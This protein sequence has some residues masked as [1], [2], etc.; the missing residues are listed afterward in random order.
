M[1]KYYLIVGLFLT[2]LKFLLKSEYEEAS[3]YKPMSAPLIEWLN[4]TAARHKRWTGRTGAI[5]SAPYQWSTI[6]AG[7][8]VAQSW[9]FPSSPSCR[10]A[11]AA[12]HGEGG[13]QS[14]ME[15]DPR[16]QK[17]L[18]LSWKPTRGCSASPRWS[19]LNPSLLQLS[20]CSCRAHIPHSPAPT[21][22]TQRGL[23]GKHHNQLPPSCFSGEKQ[24]IA[25]RIE[26]THRLH[27]KPPWELQAS[28]FNFSK[29]KR[30]KQIYLGSSLI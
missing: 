1:L 15:L 22:Q 5:P 30:R 14:S 21:R 27:P 2:Q 13:E 3:G 26:R 7:P 6:R 19:G 28:G 4:Q 11:G 20:S 24:E 25:P 12:L 9:N 29:I 8:G 10:K 17:E 18:L 23:P 16:G